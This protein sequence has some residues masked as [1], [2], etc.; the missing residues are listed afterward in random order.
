MP[1]LPASLTDLPGRF[2]RLLE[3]ST[4]PCLQSLLCDYTTD[5]PLPALHEGIRAL[6]D[7]TRAAPTSVTLGAGSHRKGNSLLSV[8]YKSC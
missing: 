7:T 6:G 1:P 3:R 2:L 4:E 5:T 8:T